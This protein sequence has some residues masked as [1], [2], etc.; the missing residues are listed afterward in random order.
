MRKTQIA[1]LIFLMVFAV[2]WLLVGV[3]LF[4]S[5]DVQ[6]AEE[7]ESMEHVIL[8]EPKTRGDVSVEEA[9]FKRRSTRRYKQGSLTL[10]E[11]SQLLWAAVGKTVDGL[12]G[13]TRAYP[14]AGASHP[15]EAYLVAG[16]VEGLPSGVY[17]Y[18]WQDHSL[19]LVID[20]DVRGDLTD[21]ALKQTMIK[22]APVSIVFT[23]I[24]IR[25]TSRYGN[26]GEV[27]YVPM[28]TGAAFQNVHLQAQALGLGTVIIGAFSDEGVKEVLN[29]KNEIPLGIM[30]VGRI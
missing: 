15:L 12:S 5:E 23:A 25:T 14:S 11:A 22:D 10:Q 21:A 7:G 20:G 19:D 17:R 8:P 2:A 27:R 16:D 13:P 30:P 24:Y 9:I 3:F 29:L 18:N 28:D 4:P 1:I 6:E 26:R